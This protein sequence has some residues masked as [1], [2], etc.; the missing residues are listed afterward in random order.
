MSEILIVDDLPDHIAFAGAILKA[1]GYKVCAATSGEAA[2]KLLNTRKA[3]D[4]LPDLIMLDIKMDGM[5]GLTLCRRIKDDSVIRDIPVIFVTSETNP[6]VIKEGF[7]AGCCDYV[8]KP[9]VR[10]E[11]LARIKTHLNI[12]RQQRELT[13]SYNELNLFCSAV[14]HDLK[15]PLN[16]INM[17]IDALRAEL[18][19]D[20]SEDTAE[21]T[22]MLK[23]K[24]NQLIRMIERLLEFTKLSGA[25]IQS[26]EINT[27]EVVKDAFTEQRAMYPERNIRLEIGELPYIHGDPVL[28]RTLFSNIIGNAVKF[29][30]KREVGMI[31]VTSPKDNFYHAILIRDN[32]AGF[33]M[34]YAGE[35]FKIF[36]RLHDYDDFPGSGVGLA[37]CER[38]MKRHGGQ[39]SLTGKENAGAEA[40]LLF[41]KK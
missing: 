12:S 29:T 33:D 7:D 9:F 38:I 3:Q 22:E 26:R 40:L 10:E 36:R 15:A 30:S 14:S 13:A 16:V 25:P 32:G 4:T 6:E 31:S 1:E 35:L 11:Y 28:V 2:L 24:S 17:L 39:I 20:I 23:G 41:P 37:L 27:A 18:G 21:I 5:S 19:E 8:Q 34:E